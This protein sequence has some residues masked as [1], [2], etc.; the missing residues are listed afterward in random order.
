MI[1]F[2]SFDND[3]KFMQVK[4]LSD[5][6]TLEADSYAF[7]CIKHADKEMLESYFT[8][9]KELHKHNIPYAV[10]LDSPAVLQY[11]GHTKTEDGSSKW[12]KHIYRYRGDIAYTDDREYKSEDIS[13]LLPLRTLLFMFA[14]HGAS[15]FILD[16]QNY[17]FLPAAQTWIDHYLLDIKLL[18]LVDS[19][20]EIENIASWST[21]HDFMYNFLKNSNKYIGI[22]GVVER[23]LL[24][25][26]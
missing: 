9:G 5:C 25:F 6:D 24:V 3:K 23:S 14:K 4:R 7:I 2:S 17:D 1:I 20:M 18:G 22:D 21:Y 8:L 15:F 10:L 11:C 26:K 16:R 12:E 13:S 19:Y